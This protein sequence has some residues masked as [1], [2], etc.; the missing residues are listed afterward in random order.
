MS[1]FHLTTQK[2]ADFSDLQVALLQFIFKSVRP[3]GDCMSGFF[4]NFLALFKQH[5]KVSVHIN[6]EYP[7][8]A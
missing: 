2:V 5:V 6:I 7:N 4:M 1:I 3:V 8:V